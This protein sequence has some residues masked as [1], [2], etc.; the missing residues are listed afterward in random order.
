MHIYITIVY[1]ISLFQGVVN[2]ERMFETKERI[3]VVMEKLK[4]D[5]LEM[6]LSSERG[7]LSERITKFLI[8]Q[9][10]YVLLL[11]LTQV[12]Y[13]ECSSHLND[14]KAMFDS[15][16]VVATSKVQE[17]SE[18]VERAVRQCKQGN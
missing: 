6:I 5:M 13:I 9:V 8:Y 14:T 15:L 18:C 2:L 16:Q 1:Y 11:E 10:N 17:L 7:K 12:Q 4:G 3:F